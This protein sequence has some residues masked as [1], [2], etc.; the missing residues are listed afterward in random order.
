MR[1]TDKQ[2]QQFHEEGYLVFENLIHGEKLKAYQELFDELVERS[3]TLPVDIPHWTFEFSEDHKPIPGFLHKIQG[4]C[5]VEP[6]VLDLAGEIEILDRVQA[7][8]GPDIDVFGT[9]F[10]PKLPNGGHLGTLASR[11]L[12]LR[13][14]HKPNCQLRY[15]PSR[16][17]PRERLFESGPQKPLVP[18][19]CGTPSKTGGT[20]ELDGGRRIESRR[21]GGARWYGGFLLIEPPPR[22]L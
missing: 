10:F 1:L 7:L 11:Q 12:L 18:S 21:S 14:E 2:V 5:V 4:V 20:W 19:D 16:H 8:V 13:H 15:L 3:H 9:K 17:R 6:K 22:N